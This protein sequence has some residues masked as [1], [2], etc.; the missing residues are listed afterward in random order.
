M[1]RDRT[2]E[3]FESNMSRIDNGD[4]LKF[5][6]DFQINKQFSIQ[7]NDIL[8]IF[9]KSSNCH[10]PLDFEQFLMALNTLAEEIHKF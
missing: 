5:C 4:F 10:L 9:N 2:F 3:Q 7:R 1:C 6:K 8:K